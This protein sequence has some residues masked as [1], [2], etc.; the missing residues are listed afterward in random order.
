MTRRA[1]AVL[2]ASCLVTSACAAGDPDVPTQVAL[3]SAA[4]QLAS[5]PV[6]AQLPHSID[7]T[8]HFDGDQLGA[9]LSATGP[10]GATYCVVVTIPAQWL[11]NQNAD[12]LASEVSDDCPPASER[13]TS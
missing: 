1:L 13:T 9:V 3:S 7:R 11:L 2:L 5:S 10:S 8:A 6:S 12:I 4:R